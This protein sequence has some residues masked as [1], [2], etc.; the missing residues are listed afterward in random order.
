MESLN[1]DV[2]LEVAERLDPVSLRE[3]VRTN[4]ALSQFYDTHSRYIW[5]SYIVRDFGPLYKALNIDLRQ[6]GPSTAETYEVCFREALNT[7]RYLGVLR[8]ERGG[9]TRDSVANKAFDHFLMLPKRL[10]ESISQPIW[11]N[12][13]IFTVLW[14]PDLLPKLIALRPKSFYTA[15]KVPGQKETTDSTLVIL[16]L[17]F[18]MSNTG[19]IDRL[20]YIYDAFVNPTEHN[21]KGIYNDGYCAETKFLIFDQMSRWQDLVPLVG[22]RR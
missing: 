14:R 12:L 5:R 17:L 3:L 1:N 6:M 16:E 10:L 9:E 7:Y 20:P 2:L 15:F 11:A 21:P 13:C 22:R 18:N 4:K 8:N 19:L